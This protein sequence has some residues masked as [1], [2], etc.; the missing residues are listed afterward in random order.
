M[1]ERLSTGGES[2]ADDAAL[3]V[4]RDDVA[5]A[6]FPTGDIAFQASDCRLLALNQLAATILKALARPLPISDLAAILERSVVCAKNQP[7][8]A[9]SYEVLA[10]LERLRLVKRCTIAPC[11]WKEQVIMSDSTQYLANPDVS[12]RIE[13]EDGAIL[14]NPDTRSCQVINAVGLEL[15]QCLSQPRRRD[16]LAVH[17]CEIYEGVSLEDAVRDIEAFLQPLVMRG[18]VGELEEGASHGL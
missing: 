13:D 7:T 12:C 9:D 16:D 8:P 14:Y 3:W 11:R 6:A 17:L 18:F 1:A 15:W 2:T 10:E 5:I 4:R